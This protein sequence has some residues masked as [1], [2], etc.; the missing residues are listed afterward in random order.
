MIKARESERRFD[1]FKSA[2]DEV[3]CKKRVL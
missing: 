1:E 3:E 2:F